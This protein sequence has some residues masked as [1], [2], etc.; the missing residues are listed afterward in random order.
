MTS[1][2]DVITFISTGVFHDSQLTDTSTYRVLVRAHPVLSPT[3]VPS[4]QRYF[5]LLITHRVLFAASFLHFHFSSISIPKYYSV[6]PS[7]MPLSSAYLSIILLFSLFHF[8]RPI[9]Y[10][11][12]NV[13]KTIHLC[14]FILGSSALPFLHHPFPIQ[15][16]YQSSAWEY[17]NYTL[18][19]HVLV[20]NV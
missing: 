15:Q 14:S 2:Q 1:P 6:V 5:P 17:T 13:S 12:Y 20:V 18:T 9:H 4:Q 3:L 11:H 10:C 8:P 16:Q 7:T 19:F